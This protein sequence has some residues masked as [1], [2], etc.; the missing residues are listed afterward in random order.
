MANSFELITARYDPFWGQPEAQV[1][2]I[3]ATKE[4]FLQIDLQV[5]VCKSVEDLTE[6][7]EVLFMSLSVYKKI[8]NV[9]NYI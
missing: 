6:D 7:V 8:I 1:S 2:H 3:L 4:T 5:V 9:N